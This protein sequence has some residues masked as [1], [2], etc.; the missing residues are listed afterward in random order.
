MAV[1]GMLHVKYIYQA[2]LTV[3]EK[4][5]QQETTKRE[6]EVARVF[7]EAKSTYRYRN[8]SWKVLNA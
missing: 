1:G 2:A 8:G 6:D 3:T 4:C 5:E 7:P